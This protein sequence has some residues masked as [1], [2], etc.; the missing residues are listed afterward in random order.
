MANQVC[1][2][3]QGGGV[4]VVPTCWPVNQ[5]S[6]L[7]PHRCVPLHFVIIDVISNFYILLSIFNLSNAM[8]FW[9]IFGP[10]SRSISCLENAGACPLG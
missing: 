2:I 4:V 8:V 7:T 6:A 10:D 1:N 9:L 5:V 3:L